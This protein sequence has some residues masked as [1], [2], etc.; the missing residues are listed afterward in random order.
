MRV[1]HFAFTWALSHSSANFCMAAS[2]ASFFARISGESTFSTTAFSPVSPF[3]TTSTLASRSS[4]K[5][6][7]SGGSGGLYSLTAIQLSKT[8]YMC[9]KYDSIRVYSYFSGNR[10]VFIFASLIIYI[11]R[12]ILNLIKPRCLLGLSFNSSYRNLNC[13]VSLCKLTLVIAQLPFLLQHK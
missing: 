8:K 11:L 13:R 4:K 7:R 9:K 5:P 12:L 6:V 3:T 1:C 10:M 2:P